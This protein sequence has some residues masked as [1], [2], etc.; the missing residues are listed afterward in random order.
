M[1]FLLTGGLVAGAWLLSGARFRRAIGS[2]TAV[3]GA[4]C[5]M[6][7]LLLLYSGYLG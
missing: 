7:L 6:V 3:A 1:I 2:E 4:A 5:T